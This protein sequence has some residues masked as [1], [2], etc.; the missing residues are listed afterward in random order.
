MTRHILLSFDAEEFDAP[1]EF[2]QLISVA[3]QFEVSRLGLERV[4]AVVE[5]V[6][7]PCTFF[8]TANFAQHYPALV[9][10]LARRHEVASHGFYH[11]RFAPGDL[12]ASRQALEQISGQKVVGFRRARMAATD[13]TLLAQAGYSYDSSANPIWLPGR[14]NHFFQ[15]RTAHLVGAVLSIPASATPLFRFP[16]FWLSFK[17]FPPALI[18]AAS[19]WVL[20]AD[21]YLNLYF[22]PWEFADL[23]AFALPGYMKRVHGAALA[24]RLEEY[25]LWL[26]GRGR[27]MIMRDFDQWFRGGS[28]GSGGSGPA[29]QDHPGK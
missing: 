17:N 8:T 18:R 1:L 12:L 2:G 19:R 28:G 7:V 15:K 20:A 27:F 22:H 21:G 29:G 4:L 26:K 14:Y 16:L 13:L 23:S 10:A 24:K 25:L 9:Q 11:S 5:R 3:D 6:G